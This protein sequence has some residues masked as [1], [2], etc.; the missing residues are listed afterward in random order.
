MWI[1]RI[2]RCRPLNGLWMSIW[3]PLLI[4]MSDP[5]RWKQQQSFASRFDSPAESG[6]RELNRLLDLLDGI[7]QGSKGDS[8]PA[9]VCNSVSLFHSIAAVFSLTKKEKRKKRMNMKPLDF[10]LPSIDSIS[11]QQPLWSRRTSSSTRIWPYRSKIR[12][13]VQQGYWIVEKRKIA[14]WIILFVGNFKPCR[15]IRS[16]PSKQSRCPSPSSICIEQ[17]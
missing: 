13:V 10:Q 12:F 17:K 11:T 3:S 9:L 2:Y 16:R 14:S 15:S 6:L 5:E 7:Q 1:E 4:Q 8:C